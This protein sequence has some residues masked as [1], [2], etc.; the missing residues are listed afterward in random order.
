[1]QAVRES[2]AAA[3]QQQQQQEQA[4]QLK[5]LHAQNSTLEEQLALLNSNL[6]DAARKQEEV[7]AQFQMSIVLN[8]AGY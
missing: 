8:T 2:Q 5:V 3:L 7:G 1:M 6:A 4:D